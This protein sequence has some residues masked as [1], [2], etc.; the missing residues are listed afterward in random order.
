[1]TQYVA[2][3]QLWAEYQ[4]KGTLDFEYEHGEYWPALDRL[5]AEVRAERKARWVEGGKLVG[6]LEDYI[7]GGLEVGA[8]GKAK[9]EAKEE[10][11]GEE[12]VEEVKKETNGEAAGE[13]TETNGEK[14]D[15]AKPEELKVA[16][17]DINEKKG[18]EKTGETKEEAKASA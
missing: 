2:P 7:A 10:V 9:G 14:T 6:E 1:M 15:E 11:N 5:G 17:L 3:E 16:G 8:A 18:E 4:D 13:G 12:K